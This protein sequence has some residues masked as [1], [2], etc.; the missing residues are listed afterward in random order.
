MSLR[1]PSSQRGAAMVSTMVFLVIALLALVGS[2]ERLHNVVQLEESSLRVASDS[3]GTA[4]ALGIALAR[5]HTGVPSESPYA[6]R[7]RLRSSDGHSALAFR[8]TH[9]QT[10]T[11]RW[12]VSTQPSA[13]ALEDCPATFSQACPLGGP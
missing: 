3:D 10:G 6:C 5:M 8:I 1:R 9:T 13:D 4:E 2:F 7:T 11:D 12:L